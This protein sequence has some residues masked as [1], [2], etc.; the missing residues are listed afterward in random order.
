MSKLSL[1]Y[2]ELT[3]QLESTYTVTYASRHPDDGTAREI[4]ISVVRG[5]KVI[6]DV[7]NAG[8]TVHGVIVPEMD[9][10]VYLVLLAVLAALLAAPA[11]LRRLFRR[12]AAIDVRRAGSV[13]DGCEDRRYASSST[14]IHDAP[15]RR[16]DRR[17]V[18][19][20]RP[21][22]RAIVR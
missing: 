5:G 8:Y 18:H 21:G 16:H 9:H 14:S 4:D 11:G 19:R 3:Q 6:S 20:P 1:V 7:A 22:G 12:T 13:S 17:P 15:P 10:R 2:E